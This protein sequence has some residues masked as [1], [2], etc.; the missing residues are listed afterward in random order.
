MRSFACLLALGLALAPAAA[1]AQDRA[2]VSAAVKGQ[3]EL[4]REAQQIVGRQ[5]ESGEDIFL[6]DLIESGPRSGMQILLLDET[7]FTIGPE[8]AIEIDEFV[9]DPNTGAG[10]VSAEVVKGVFRFVT[11]KVAERNPE[12]MDVDL[13]VG[14][15]GIRGTIVAGVARPDLV[16]TILLGPGPNNQTGE[17]PGAF[18]ANNAGESKP[19][20]KPGWGAEFEEGKP[21]RVHEVDPALIEEILAVL[22]NPQGVSWAELPILGGW[23]GPTGDAGRALEKAGI[24][25]LERGEELDRDRTD[26][27]QTD[28]MQEMEDMESDDSDY[29]E[30]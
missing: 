25:P 17:R 9:Y 24:R 22:D 19:V 7:V 28:P 26:A 20:R 29:Y 14:N 21:P 6:R 5:V 10:E 3:V 11:G 18:D 8:S 2:G 13:P 12:A 30:Y 15:I 16:L 23:L 4:T 27:A 1:R